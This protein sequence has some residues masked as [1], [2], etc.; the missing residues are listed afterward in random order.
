MTA[1][2]LRRGKQSQRSF[3]IIACRP[4]WWPASKGSK[5]CP[6]HRLLAGPRRPGGQQ[7]TCAGPACQRRGQRVPERPQTVTRQQDLLNHGLRARVSKGE[8]D[9]TACRPA[10]RVQMP[11]KSA[12]VSAPA[13]EGV[14]EI[15]QK[16]R[17]L[18]DSLI[19]NRRFRSA[20][21]FESAG[22]FAIQSYAKTKHD[23]SNARSL[24]VG[25]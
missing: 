14:T 24:P 9:R 4:A 21:N 7:A 2:G 3:Q 12:T 15:D 19:G 22:P 5:A 16:M 10:P 1:G 6:N 23:S 17:L 18:I 11:N 20:D 8:K 13:R 25:A